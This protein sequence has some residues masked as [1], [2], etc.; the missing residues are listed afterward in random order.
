MPPS[1]D[2][3]Q[4]DCRGRRGAAANIIPSPTGAAKAVGGKL[5]GMA[6]RVPTSDVPVVDLRNEMPNMLLS[7]P[8]CGAVVRTYLLILHSS[9]GASGK[10]ARSEVNYPRVALDEVTQCFLRAP[11]RG[12]HPIKFWK[13]LF[14]QR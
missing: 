8:T 9:K 5:T 10:P 11:Y 4:R 2:H 14:G 12:F 6:F 1:T 13:L 7:G 3:P